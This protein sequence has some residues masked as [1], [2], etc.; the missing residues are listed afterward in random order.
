MT[1]LESLRREV[2]RLQKN[3]SSGTKYPRYIMVLFGKG[4]EQKNGIFAELQI[5][6][7]P[8]VAEIKNLTKQG[9]LRFCKDHRIDP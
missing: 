8:R 4:G 3:Q 7:G 2:E 9:Y 6:D 5:M 1:S